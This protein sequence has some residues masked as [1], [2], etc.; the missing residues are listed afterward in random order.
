MV[1]RSSEGRSRPGA[2]IE[3]FTHLGSSLARARHFDMIFEQRP[4]VS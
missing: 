3:Y 2:G 1:V 4:E